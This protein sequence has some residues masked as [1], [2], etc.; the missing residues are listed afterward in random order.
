M[1]KRKDILLIK[2][3]PQVTQAHIVSIVESSA[4]EVERIIECMGERKI[5][6]RI[7]NNFNRYKYWN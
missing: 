2:E 3:K 6:K 5:G 7:K 4:R 1:S